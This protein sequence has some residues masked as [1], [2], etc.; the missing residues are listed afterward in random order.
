MKANV[1]GTTDSLGFLSIPHD[2]IAP[3][4]GV[5]LSARLNSITT[6]SGDLGAAFIDVLTNYNDAQTHDL[7]AL[8]L[9]NWNDMAWDSKSVSVD[10]LY[11]IAPKP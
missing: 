8:R 11:A 10:I 5:I 7:Y 2:V 9:K 6:G 1:S 4:T 3:S